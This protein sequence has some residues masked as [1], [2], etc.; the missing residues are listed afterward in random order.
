M[1]LKEFSD[2]ETLAEPSVLR[3]VAVRLREIAAFEGHSYSA[4][5]LA[6]EALRALGAEVPP[7]PSEILRQK[8]GRGEI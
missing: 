6:A 7:T 2:A 3:A 4:A 5:R 1:S 8:R